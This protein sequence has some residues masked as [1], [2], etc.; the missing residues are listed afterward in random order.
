MIATV[1]LNPAFDKTVYIDRLLPNDANRISQVETDA[2]GKGINASRVLKELGTPTVALGFIGG[3]T[4]SFIE[5]VL[6][7]EGV[8][9][10]FVRVARETR[11]NISIQESSGTPPTMLNE[12]GPPVSERDLAELY[13]RVRDVAGKSAMVILGG[14][15]TAGVP[16]GAYRTMSEI[17]KS[18]GAKVILDSDGEPMCLGMRAVPFM[19]TPNRDEVKRLSGVDINTIE[20]AVEALHIL[21]ADGIELVVISLG[22]DG[23]IAG[24]KG[25]V[26]RA[27]PPQVKVV[28]TIG[29][30]DSMIAGIAHVLARDGSIED[31]LR[32]GT[33]AGAATAMT[34]GTE[35]GR[36]IQI[37]ALLDK[38]TVERIR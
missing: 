29:S 33:A 21:Q 32:M 27:V 28:S 19:I 6:R 36:K 2:G 23:A 12:P 7:E 8:D 20:D 11:T 31:A 25:E 18:A 15:L 14:S 22:K 26:L 13:A 3:S 30:G 38:V 35:I 1:T 37:D 16:V 10:D 5:F 24:F 9:T 34:D 17:V 4:G